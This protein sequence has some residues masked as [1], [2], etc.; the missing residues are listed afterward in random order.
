MQRCS[1][2]HWQKVH[3]RCFTTNSIIEEWR[4]IQNVK[5]VQ[6]PRGTEIEMPKS[7]AAVCN[8]LQNHNGWYI[9]LSL[10]HALPC[11][12]AIFPFPVHTV[13]VAD[14]SWEPCL[15]SFVLK[16]IHIIICWMPKCISRVQGVHTH[17]KTF[18]SLQS[19]GGRHPVLVIM[20]SRAH[21]WSEKAHCR[22]DLLK[23]LQSNL[24]SSILLLSEIIVMINKIGN[25]TMS[26]NSNFGSLK[27][28]LK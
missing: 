27:N 14:A 28:F 6:V 8:R 26:S 9:T 17:A 7:A 5:V 18:H 12:R 16:S 24:S 13:N 10:E 3:I 23:C 20:F 22:A 21:S 1:R 15:M 11:G 4:P 19:C 25:G 2:C